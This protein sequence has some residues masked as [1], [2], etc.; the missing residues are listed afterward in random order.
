[1]GY[2]VCWACPAAKQNRQTRTLG[3][4]WSRINGTVKRG[5]LNHRLSSASSLLI[6]RV[7]FSTSWFQGWSLY[8]KMSTLPRDGSSHSEWLATLPKDRSSISRWQ[9]LFEIEA[10]FNMTALPQMLAP[11]QDSNSAS[12]HQ[13]QNGSSILRWQLHVQA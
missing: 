8:F 11:C 3:N 12:R 13:L 10:L 2:S 9:L 6:L 4:I 1:M 5:H 7:C